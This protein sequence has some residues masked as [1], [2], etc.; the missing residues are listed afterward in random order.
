MKYQIQKVQEVDL[1]AIRNLYAQARRFMSEH[2]NP[3]QW[4]NAYPP[5]ALLRED[6]AEGKLY[7]VRDTSGIHGVFYFCVEEDPTYAVIRDGQWHWNTPYGVIHRIA[8]DGSGEILRAALS[9][10]RQKISHLRID[11]HEK[12]YV[13]QKALG[14]QGFSRCGTIFLAD[15]SPRIAFDSMDGPREA[16]AEELEDIL[17]LYLHLHETQLPP[18]REK[19]E[20]VWRKIMQE[21]DHHLIIYEADGKVVSSC[22]CAVIPNLTRGLRPYALIENVVTHEAYRG[23]GYASACLAKA[24][25]IAER[26]GC[27][28]MMLLT[29]ASDPKTH[30]FYQNAGYN[31]TDKTAYIQWI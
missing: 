25:Q 19:R 7:K 3:D 17:N 14:K 2:G 4:G 22:V 10:A 24:R 8:G 12:N 28:K 1:P 5:E 15:G 21:E 31:S 30:S 13:M 9:F 16:G 26:A 23:R 6:I 18:D 20:A 27:Y 29:G 11:T